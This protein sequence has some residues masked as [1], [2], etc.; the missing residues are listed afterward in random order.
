MSKQIESS[1]RSRVS[2][3]LKKVVGYLT[4]RSREEWCQDFLKHCACAEQIGFG[5]SGPMFRMTDGPIQFYETSRRIG[6]HIRGAVR[7]V[8]VLNLLPGSV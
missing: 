8:N 2:A 7:S 5:K 6:L 3:I 4:E 1:E